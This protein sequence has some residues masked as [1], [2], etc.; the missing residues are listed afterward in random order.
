MRAVTDVLRQ[1]L[2]PL[3]IRATLISPGFT[4]T[5][6]IDSAR[7]P[8]ERAALE[9]RR[10]ATA[11]SPDTVAAAIVYC[12]SQPDSVNVGELTVRPTIQP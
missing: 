6:F 4:D 9:V 5:G 12:L 8:D 2:A 3:G 1:E 7:D 11:M 10:D